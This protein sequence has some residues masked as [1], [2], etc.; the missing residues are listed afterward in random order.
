MEL[1]KLPKGEAPKKGERNTNQKKKE[2]GG[3]PVHHMLEKLDLSGF[4]ERR[5]S[6]AGMKELI[7]GL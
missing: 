7:E 3:V 2:I 5:F 6:R 4:K 1:L